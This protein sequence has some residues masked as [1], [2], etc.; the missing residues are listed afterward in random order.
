MRYPIALVMAAA[1]ACAVSALGQATP[2]APED[3]GLTPKTD[4]IYINRQTTDFT[5][6]NN[7]STESLGV[8]IANGGNVI[9]GW[10]DDGDGVA[11]FE[12][13]WTMLDSGGLLITPAT[14]QTALQL[15]ESITSHWL[16]Y[17]RKDGSAVY[18][19]TSWGPKIKANIF[20]DGIGM[21]AISY[22][23]S[24][25]VA[26]MA[27][28]DDANSGDVNTVQLL[29]NDGKPINILG[30]VSPEYATADPG[31]IRIGDF[32]YLAN[33]NVVIVGE[34]R[35]KDDL[36]NLYGGDTSATH[37]VYRVL[38]PSGTV[39]KSE[40]LVSSEP[41]LSE[42][43]HGV[44]VTKNGFAVRINTPQGV[45]IRLFDNAGNPT[46]TNIILATLANAPQAGGGGRGDGAGFHGN[47]DNL[48][49]HACAAG[50]D[51]WVTVI[52]AD[53][54]LVYSK[55]V[56]ADAGLA[57]VD[58]MDA[59][60][61]ADGN[62]IVVFQAK[63]EASAPLAVLGRRVDAKGK[64][65]GS[66]FYVS[67]KEIPGTAGYDADVP[68]IAWRAGQAVV[69]WRTKNDPETL[70]PSSGDPM[71]V[72]AVRMFSTFTPGSIESVGLTRIVKDTPVVKTTDNALGNWEPNISVLGTSTFL[73]EGNTFAEG[74]V[75]EQRYVVALQPAAGGTMKLGEG[76]YADNGTPYKGAINLSRQNGNPGR[77]AGDKRPGAVNF[78]VG[79]ETSVHGF[80]E[81]QG[82]NRWNL[83]FD[84][85]SD[86]RYGTIQIFSLNTTTLA[87]T[88]L[89]KAMDSANGRLTS[90]GPAGNQISR[91]GGE[92]AGLDN[93][94][95]VSV[96]QD[97]SRVR[98]TDA[99]CTVATI[100]APNGSIVK[101]SWVVATSDIWGNVAA[102]K[103][104]FAVRCK[105][106][107]GTAT[108]WI[109]FYDNA[110]NLKGHIDQA[111][112]GL[113][114]DTGR[115]DGTRIFAHINSPFVFLTG[116]A[117]NTSIV[118]VSAFDSR[119]QSFAAN[120]DV[121][122]GAFTGNFDR[123][124]GASDAL[125]RLVVSWVSQPTGYAN[126]QVAARV[127][128]FDATNKKFTALTKSFFPFVNYGTNDIRSLQMSIAMTT[129]QICVAAKGEINYENVPANGVDSPK[130]VNFYTV[131][132]HPVPQDDP[133]TP[134]TTA[135][136]TLS[137][138]KASATSATISWVG[139][140][141]TLQSKNSLSDTT[142]TTVGTT[143]PATVTIGS[144]NKFY[145][146]VK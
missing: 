118:K 98:I 35:Q 18:G 108:R 60:I 80:T 117:A 78:L 67:E 88:P 138:T 115:G 133:T 12:A 31:N 2:G 75:S 33:G 130:E 81:F 9:V 16:S 96:V 132:T 7:N 106:T 27:A 112:S 39:I 37:A 5:D 13:V 51:V 24:A 129:K 43:W 124:N 30:G 3:N 23:L 56:T 34:S 66:V 8:A 71:K 110:G 136:P 131:F 123:A 55:S 47:G 58:R 87:Q 145:R 144:G 90:G 22:G 86:G 121:N 46:S 40:S 41:I 141:F 77:V 89:S 70:D 26:E 91:F 84:R 107:D 79:G 134:V 128:A 95:F 92:V 17:F 15:G 36:V 83:G 119:D 14:E 29:G 109:Y 146:L 69:A 65:L 102:Y 135:A 11:D 28:Y 57:S 54:T 74:S 143:S 85:L 64:A 125:N 97:N 127:L 19:G 82:D 61:D 6:V 126:Q 53:G 94:N 137:I 76:F 48:Y 99:D 93:G 120:A 21:G 20:G 63:V 10:E 44:G 68:R 32:D 25:E 105:P 73:I 72:V 113:S 101:E 49:V 140:G 142:W 50:T 111:A 1:T 100:F 122:E 114:Y 4:T 104:G 116:R 59:A 62:V 45:A 103:G 42:I 38:T 139:T 52:K